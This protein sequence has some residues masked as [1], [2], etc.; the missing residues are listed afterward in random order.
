M[1]KDYLIIHPHNIFSQGNS[2]IPNFDEQFDVVDMYQLHETDVS[3]YKCMILVNFVDQDYLYEERARIAEFLADRKIVCFF[4][5]VVTDWLP[6]AK[7]F[8]AKEI[9]SHLDYDISIAKPHPIFEGVL[10]EDMTVNKGVKG[11]FARGHHPQPVGAEVLLTLPGGEPVTYIDRDTT[12]GTI[13]VHSGGNLFEYK[14]M[15]ESVRKTTE[16]ISPQMMQWVQD[17]YERLQE[18]VVVN[19]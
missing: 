14:S 11:F 8:I 19:A 1:T 16:R 5:N 6:G 18:G 17:E 12:A 4:G 9:R 10:E 2:S 13:F 7:P 15:D 3:G